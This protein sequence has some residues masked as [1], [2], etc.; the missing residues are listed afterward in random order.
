LPAAT[1]LALLSRSRGEQ[2]SRGARGVAEQMAALFGARLGDREQLL[3]TSALQHLAAGR[4]DESTL[5]FIR[6]P[7]AGV[8]AQ[9]QVADSERFLVA[10]TDLPQLLSV[11]A[12]RAPLEEFLGPLRLRPIAGKAAGGSVVG[13]ALTFGHGGQIGKS[14]PTGLEMLWHVER[15]RYHVVLGPSPAAPLLAAS[16]RPKSGLGELQRVREA[17]EQ[18]QAASLAIL[19]RPAAL[20][21]VPEQAVL[22]D[23]AVLV[24]TG[25]ER[26]RGFLTASVPS[27]VLQSFVEAAAAP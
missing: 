12:V 3:L 13:H 15:D 21:L 18:C 19:L 2:R 9:G 10:L 4:G 1:A 24:A 20:R 11:G 27:D 26:D 25:R 5:A 8:V 6:G 23:A 16:R 17:L 22:E 7:A 14:V